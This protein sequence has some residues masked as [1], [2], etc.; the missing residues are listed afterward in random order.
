MATPVSVVKELEMRSATLPRRKFTRE[1][2]HRLVGSGILREEERV[3]LI[4]GDI[5]PMAPSTHEHATQTLGLYER[6]RR[7][8]GK[9][10]HVRIQSPL[11]LG[12]SEPVPDIAV[13]KGKLTDYK[14]AHPTSAVLIIEVAQSS[15]PYDR[16]VKTSLYAKAGIPEYWII[17]L[18]HRQLEVY[19]EPIESPDS[20]F[21]YTYRLRLLLQP[22]DTLAPLEK[23]TRIVR[24]AHL[25][26][27]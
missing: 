26:M 12:E 17:N 25:F 1:E 14:H 13:V 10:Y 20:L 2:F 16:T 4:E 15:L 9:G 22:N 18:E 11:A 27:L 23:P 6:V 7:L 3:E 19:R 24:V 8:F 21:G 5:V